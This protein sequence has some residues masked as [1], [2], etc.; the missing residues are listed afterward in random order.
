MM[1]GIP[2]AQTYRLRWNTDSSAGL[3]LS[4]EFRE[5]RKNSDFFDVTLSSSVDTGGSLSLKAHKAILS[6]Y[7]GVFREMFQ[8]YPARQ[9]PFIY[10]SGISFQNLQYILDFMY[11]GEANVSQ[12]HLSTFLGLA[13]ELQIKGLQM[14]K[15]SSP[16]P[17]PPPMRR[18]P[19]SEKLNSLKQELFESNERKTTG[20]KGYKGYPKDD[21]D[22]WAPTQKRKYIKKEKSRMNG[23]EDWAPRDQ[24]TDAFFKE[25]ND[26]LTESD[27]INARYAREELNGWPSKKKS[28]FEMEEED[29]GND[30]PIPEGQVGDLNDFIKHIPPK[31]QEN[32]Q[33]RSMSRC[34]ICL[35]EFRRDKIK[36]HV[37]K[38]H[39]QYLN[40]IPTDSMA[41]EDES[42]AFVAM[43]NGEAPDE[44]NNNNEDSE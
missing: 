6:A 1:T 24:R 14:N 44:S 16:N 7:S 28:R 21:D 2:Q 23:E 10:L 30:D 35:K 42:N 15:E 19:V 38:A 12:A 13:E 9:D 33:K 25:L 34:R 41:A 27:L 39:P 20:G 18:R 36:H 22:S 29:D 37:V 8:Q 5:F 3:D 17:P 31:P 4:E 40:S 32:G 26:S 43:A 11:N